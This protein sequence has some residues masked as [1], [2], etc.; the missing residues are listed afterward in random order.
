MFMRELLKIVKKD[1]DLK[2]MEAG[3]GS[4]AMSSY[5]AKRNE[6]TVLDLSMNA[7]EIAKGN[8]RKNKTN[9]WFILGDIFSMPLS[10]DSF[11]VVW[12]QGVLEHFT[13]P[14]YAMKEMM[15]V[16]KRDG[17]V[18]IFIPVF[19]SPLHLF[20]SF[21]SLPCLRRLWLFDHQYF[22]TPNT[23]KLFMEKAGYEGAK[24]KRLWLESFGF[25]QIGYCQKK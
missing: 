19:F 20:Y 24:V 21:L 10:D 15:R 18:V 12:N 6:V 17:Y 14:V 5:M 23:F 4:G 11:E 3:C 8:F 9:G 1:R 13:D 16:V 25:S 22:F 7:L 2:I